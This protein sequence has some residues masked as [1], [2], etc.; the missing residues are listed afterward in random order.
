M[1]WR[2]PFAAAVV[3]ASV[4]P[5][6]SS[7]STVSFASNVPFTPAIIA[8]AGT[9]DI[10][11]VLSESNACG[12]RE[13]LRLERSD[14]D[15]RT[16]I[17]EAV[18]PVTPVLGG[19]VAPIGNLYFANPR[20]G[21]A[22]EFTSTGAKWATTSIFLTRDGGR[23]WARESVGAHVSIFGF[24]STSR[25]FYALTEQCSVGKKGRCSHIGLS[26]SSVGTSKWETL[27]L[28][29]QI[30]KYWDDFQIAAFG[31]RVWLSTQNQAS[32]PY[33]PYLAT[34]LNA[35]A[36]FTVAV[37]PQLSSVGSCALLPVSDEILWAECD[38][39]MMRGDIP[40]SRDAGVRWQYDQKSQL[41]SFGFGVF[42]PIGD[43]AYFINELHLRTLFRTRSEAA[44][45]VAVGTV[46]GS[47]NWLSLDITTA[48][49]GLALSE[50]SGGSSPDILWRVTDGGKHWSRVEIEG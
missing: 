1:T 15:G 10:F 38:Q 39:G 19:S 31:S 29:R 16:F 36:S 35:G 22:E 3:V 41:G 43:V 2:A 17:P 14:N 4:L 37:Q 21:Y 40:Y 34:S 11:Y 48:G 28:P 42:E 13:C 24:A 7:L 8:R 6:T 25:Y 32:A 33:S 50:N 23:S 5:L 20:V 18:P 44:T 26:R 47:F 9:T 12:I 45:P 27:E 46:P 30:R 49:Q